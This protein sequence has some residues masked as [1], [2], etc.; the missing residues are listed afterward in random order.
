MGKDRRGRSQDAGRRP[1]VRLCVRMCAH[2]RLE[3]RGRERGGA[4][5]RAAGEG[6]RLT[7][8]LWGALNEWE[9]GRDV[10]MRGAT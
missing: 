3:V 10:E 9:A 5:R 1:W 8:E 4:E 2:A 7:A 6:V